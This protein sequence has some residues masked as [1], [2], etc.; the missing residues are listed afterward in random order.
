MLEKYYKYK[1]QYKEFIILIRS[2]NFYE[3]IDNDSLIM[4]KLFNYKLTR[5]SNTLKCGFPINSLATVSDYLKEKHVSYVVVDGDAF[6][7]FESEKNEYNNYKIDSDIIKYNTLRLEKI[8]KL[9]NGLVYDESSS[10]LLDSIEDL[11]NERQ[12]SNHN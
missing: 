11:I 6:E 12:T 2:G 8:I 10:S 1:L 9:L 4:N 5:L 3:T 7:V